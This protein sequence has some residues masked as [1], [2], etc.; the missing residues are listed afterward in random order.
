[1]PDW[2]IQFIIGIS[3][4][5]VG[6]AIAG[7]FS[8]KAI[9][10]SFEK[11]RELDGRDKEEK[12]KSLLT[13][14]DS[15][16]RTVWDLYMQ[17]GGRILE[18]LPPGQPLL[19]FYPIEQEYFVVYNSNASTIG[20][21]SDNKLRTRLIMTY[22]KAKGLIDSFKFNNSLLREYQDLLWTVDNPAYPRHF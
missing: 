18:E 4:A 11:Q 8:L 17:R 12:L 6:A 21:I 10:H 7:Y 19:I 13:A 5:L 3:A 20:S 9:D 1:M 15:E 16:L 22:T 2:S 14:L